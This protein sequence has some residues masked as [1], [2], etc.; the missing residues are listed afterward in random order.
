[1]RWG[2]I[3]HHPSRR[4]EV[5]QTYS[6][7]AERLARERPGYVLWCLGTSVDPVL[8]H[9]SKVP[10]GGELTVVP[11]LLAPGKHYL[12]DVRALA[13]AIAV[14]HPRLTVTVRPPLLED[15]AFLIPWLAGL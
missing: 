13:D 14:A 11:L 3:V 10:R 7:L 1:M 8:W 6:A 5:A 9:A 4:A 15:D 2:V 12:E